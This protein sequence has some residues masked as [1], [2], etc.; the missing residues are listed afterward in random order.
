[1][2]IKGGTLHYALLSIRSATA[3]RVE[4]ARCDVLTRNRKKHLDTLCVLTWYS[5]DPSFHCTTKS[6][7]CAAGWNITDNG[8]RNMRRLRWLHRLLLV[9]LGVLATFAKL[10]LI[11]ALSSSM[12]TRTV[13]TRDSGRMVQRGLGGV[14]L[15]RLQSTVYEDDEAPPLLADFEDIDDED[16]EDDFSDS[17]L[18]SPLSQVGG[19]GEE[20]QDGWYPGSFSRQ[21]NWLEEATEEISNLELGSLTEDDVESVVGIMAAWVRR[22]SIDAAM[23]VE[24]LLK[25]LVDDM[26]AGNTDIHMTT[27]MYTIVSFWMDWT[28]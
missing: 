4:G 9:G 20:E 25:R 28:V 2:K 10:G 11:H 21:E 13:T 5:I 7:Q 3:R 18:A 23:S 24:K 27:R 16:G 17:F 12:A 15:T 22:R 6:L 14:V 26:R 1:M 8:R 19:G